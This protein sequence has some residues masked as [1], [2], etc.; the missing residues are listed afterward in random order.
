MAAVRFPPQRLRLEHPDH[1]GR[2]RGTGLL[3]LHRA[4]GGPARRRHLRSAGRPAPAGPRPGPPAPAGTAPG[5]G[6]AAVRGRHPR[7]AHQLWGRPLLWLQPG[8]GKRPTR[9]LLPAADHAPGAGKAV[10]SGAS[11]AHGSHQRR[12]QGAAALPAGAAAHRGAGQAAEHRLAGRR[13]LARR[14]PQ[15]ARHAADP[16]L[17]P[18]RPALRQPLL[19]RQRHAHR[20]VQPVLQP[21]GQPVV[22]GAR[23]PRRQPADRRTAAAE[24]PDQAVHQ[25]ALQLSGVRQDPVRQGAARA[26]GR[27]RRRRFLGARPPQR[28]EPARLRRPA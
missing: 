15:P 4:R 12:T 3:G 14:Q 7:R 23:R 25:R 11:A 17:R 26:D 13:I 8:A 27:G 19:R 5:L 16:R 20:H 22:P 9:T 21:A 24:L 28:E 2:H 6:V 10:R 1:A 18:A